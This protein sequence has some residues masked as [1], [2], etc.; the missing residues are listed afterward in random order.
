[1]SNIEEGGNY[2][3]GNISGD[4]KND[5]LITSS[6]NILQEDKVSGNDNTIGLEEEHL[7]ISNTKNNDDNSEKT[8]VSEDD[9]GKID[10]IYC[11][12]PTID[13]NEYSELSS[14]NSD[15]LNTSFIESEEEDKYSSEDCQ[16]TVDEKLKN[17]SDNFPVV[18]KSIPHFIEAIG[19]SSESGCDSAN[20][21][22][23]DNTLISTS[24]PSLGINLKNNYTERYLMEEVKIENDSFNKKIILS[25]IP[26]E[27]L[28]K[29]SPYNEHA[30]NLM[31]DKIAQMIFTLAQVG[32]G[33]GYDNVSQYESLFIKSYEICG[34]AF[35]KITGYTFK[36]FILRPFCKPYFY[37]Q[38]DDL[39]GNSRI[40]FNTSDKELIELG[41]SI[42]KT[43]ETYDKILRRKIEGN[44][45]QRD[46]HKKN[47]DL[48]VEKVRW[49][50]LLTCAPSDIP[51]V[52]IN[53]FREQFHTVYKENITK[54]YL[55]SK[56]LR[57]K[58]SGVV[59]LYFSDEL[60]FIS[61]PGTGDGIKIICDVKTR[62][63]EI[64]KEIDYLRS[65]EYLK[66]KEEKKTGGE[67]KKTKKKK[68]VKKEWKNAS[69]ALDIVNS[70][71]KN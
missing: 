46:N 8:K 19:D 25:N 40:I 7:D 70:L 31:N 32:E 60:E 53:E 20:F 48:L 9:S 5:V 56:F 69:V 13:D 28:I 26:L 15:V 55:Y 57:T 1:M 44:I 50:A 39:C 33:L 38:H 10:D 65:E 41:K 16:N 17:N 6:Q 52:S 63:E 68:D 4:T 35:K 43:R 36:E 2:G 34:K 67:K 54:D 22:E 42:T 61:A 62:I 12:T 64:K 49:L 29:Y 59:K 37:I 71:Q 23:Y 45:K 47:V 21:S 30:K 14:V 24:I 3:N 66:K 18:G 51:M 58:F 11:E 27:I